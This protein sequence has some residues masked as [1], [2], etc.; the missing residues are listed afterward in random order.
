MGYKC[1]IL[2][3][4][5][6]MTEELPLGLGDFNTVSCCVDVNNVSRTGRITWN[7]I[8]FPPYGMHYT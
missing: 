4:D 5:A 3:R 2:L 6:W 8:P 7:C 1:A